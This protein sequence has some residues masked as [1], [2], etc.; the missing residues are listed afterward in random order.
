MKTT[1]LCVLFVFVIHFQ[2]AGGQTA[3]SVEECR[4]LALRNSTASKN[5]K[6]DKALS[7]ETRRSALTNYFPNVSAGGMMF[8]AQK[9]LMEM[10]TSG[11]N[12]PVYDGNP[13]HLGRATQFAYMPASTI[14]LMKNGTI[15]YVNIVQPIFAGGRIINGNKLAALGEEVSDLQERLVRN[16]TSLT[17]EEQYWQL[18]SLAEKQG[19]VQG[20]MELLDGLLR[21][22][23]DAYSSGLCTR[24]DLLKVQLKRSEVVLN[25]SKLDHGMTVA[26]M[27]FCR[28]LGIPYDSTLVLKDTLTAGDPPP[29]YQVDNKLALKSRAEYTL[30]LASLRAEELQTRMKLGEYLPQA[31]VGISGMYMKLDEGKSRTLGLVFGTLQVPISAWW[32]ASYVL[33]GRSVKEEIARNNFK[34]NVELLELQMEKT[35]RDLT[36]AYLQVQLSY[37]ARLQAEE[38]VR[39]SRD[40]YANGI[41]TISDVLEAQAM[42]QQTSDQRTDAKAVYRTKVVTYL[43][44][45]GRE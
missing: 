15:G 27:A 24:N 21:Q 29:T 8:Q 13:A 4:Q 12:L 10:N 28:H 9:G 14:E 32:D 41:V 26:R 37:E 31:G 6:L 35:W 38:N 5:G 39:V 3:L 17:T 30:L 43:Q 45:T 36:D 40:G 20:Y 25:K 33:E 23:Q 2:N 44:M 7:R 1:Y 42:L 16:N 22:V 34:E 18:A 11:G 19:T